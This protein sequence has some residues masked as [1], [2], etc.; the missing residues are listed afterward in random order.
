MNNG[1]EKIGEFE[2]D[3]EALAKPVLKWTLILSILFVGIHYLINPFPSFSIS[4][5]LLSILFIIGEY[6]LL[7]F[8]HEICH[9]IGFYV[10]CGS[11]ISQLKMGLDLKIG[12]AYA[13]TTQFM[14]NKDARKALLLPFWLTGVLPLIAGIY[15]DQLT[16]TLVSA[17]LIVGAYGDFAMYKKLRTVPSSIYV[18]DDS[19]QPKLHLYKKSDVHD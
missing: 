17:W 13:T 5:F 16:L 4:G 7:I 15:Y 14:R 9:L 10:F 1:F 6:I 2:L 12:I 8:L 19:T 3:M 11:S 18:L